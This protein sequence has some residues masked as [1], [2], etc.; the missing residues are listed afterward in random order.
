MVKSVPLSDHSVVVKPRRRRRSGMGLLLIFL[1]LL[2][3]S[4][5]LLGF[6]FFSPARLSLAQEQLL[7]VVHGG[8]QSREERT[9]ID[10]CIEG[11]EGG[12]AVTRTIRTTVFNDGSSLSVVF[13]SQPSPTTID[14]N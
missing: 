10:A 9:F 14:C 1:L 13:S 6:G 8:V 12:Q 2:F 3:F 11:L 5:T 4:G 7:S